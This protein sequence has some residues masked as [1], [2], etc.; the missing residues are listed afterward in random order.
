M[1]RRGWELRFIEAF[2][3]LPAPQLVFDQ[4]AIDAPHDLRLLQV[5]HHLRKTPVALGERAVPIAAIGPGQKFSPPGFLHA[6]PAGTLEDLGTCIFGDH[7]LHLGQQFAL[8]RIA[9]RVLQENELEVYFL[10]F[11]NEQPLMGVVPGES[12]RGQ[13]HHR[14]ELPPLR[15]IP[16]PV[17]AGAI[18]TRAA[19]AVVERGMVRQ[20]A[21]LLL[22]NVVGEDWHL[23]GNRP[24]LLLMGCGHSGVESHLHGDPPDVPE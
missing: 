22:V 24:L 16:Q 1:P 13:D 6:T 11:L 3:H 12:I 15:T 23:A 20:E 9:A 17:Q 7:A 5:D 14:I 10:K 2:R 18:E 4:Q 8:W 19:D 21:P